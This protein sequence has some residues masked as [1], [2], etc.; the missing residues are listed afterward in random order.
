MFAQKQLTEALK[1][2][3]QRTT[4]TGSCPKEKRER[5]KEKKSDKKNAN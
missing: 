3:N 2:T 5:K 1:P 4:S